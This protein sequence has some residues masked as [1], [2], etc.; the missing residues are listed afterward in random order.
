MPIQHSAIINTAKARNWNLRVQQNIIAA[1]TIRIC[2]SH[3]PVFCEFVYNYTYNCESAN[4]VVGEHLVG[5][6][7]LY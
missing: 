7:L 5:R 1:T 4:F 6:G 2:M 3:S